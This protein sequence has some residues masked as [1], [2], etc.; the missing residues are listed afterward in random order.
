MGNSNQQMAF[1]DEQT[2]PRPTV[3]SGPRQGVSVAAPTEGLPRPQLHQ[4]TPASLHREVQT[5]LALPRPMIPRPRPFGQAR[6]RSP[7]PFVPDSRLS[8]PSSLVTSIGRPKGLG[9][10]QQRTQSNL[11]RTKKPSTNHQL[12]QM[13]LQLLSQLGS[14][15]S[16]FMEIQDSPNK[17][18]LASLVIDA[19]AASTLSRYFSCMS[20]FLQTCTRLQLDIAKVT[21]VQLLDVFLLGSKRSGLDPS[22]TIKALTW[23][24][25]HAGVAVFA[26]SS[27][28]LMQSW[29][30][31]KV[32]RDRRES[33]P[34]PLYV[35]IQ[36]ERRL[37]QAGCN[38]TERL[39]L[40][41]FLL[42]IWSGLRFS[43]LQRVTHSSL[44][45]SYSEIRGLCWRTKTCSR[46][47]PWGTTSSG[48]LSN[49]DFHGQCN[50]CSIGIIRL[51]L[52]L[53]LIQIS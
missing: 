23:F 7:V 43:D 25:T 20:K 34:L 33:L 47:Q 3:P 4:Q 21:A 50:F 17:V 10:E 11:M 29:R 51:A 35:V 13:W 42:M 31:S 14:L 52:N 6:S 12:L 2:L 36:W 27:H 46:G 8:Q 38:I 15:S 9:S 49:G 24:C 1:L 40:G 30:N 22:M 18:Q 16:I 39:V 48:F 44:M 41:G 45:A 26:I 37:L 32:P 5:E 19:F 28:S 53:V